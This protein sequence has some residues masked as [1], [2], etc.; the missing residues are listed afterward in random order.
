MSEQD[1]WLGR[2]DQ[3]MMHTF[4]TPARVFVSGQGTKLRDSDGREYIDLFSGIAVG[5]LGH[6]HP[7]IIEAVTNQVATLGHISNL[8]ASPTQIEL[9]ERLSGLV[10]AAGAASAKVYFANSGAEANEA[11]F[12]ITRLS[13]RKRIIAMTG[14]FHGRT[15]GALALTSTAK[16]REPFN[17]LPGQ[18][19]FVPY[20]DAEALAAVLDTTVAAVVLETIQGES[21]VVPA[22]EGYLA[23][24]RELCDQYGALLWVDEVQTGI[25]RCGEWLTSIA[26]GVIP[27][28]ITLAKG[29]GNGIPI[30]ATIA[31]GR[32]AELFTPGSHGSTFAGNPI[33]CAAGLAVL[34]TISSGRLLERTRELGDYLEALITSLN[35]PLI[36]QVRGRGLLL[37]I[38]LG[39]EIA[40]EIVAELLKAGWITN[41]PRPDVIRIAPPLVIDIAEL[42]GFVQTLDAML[43]GRCDD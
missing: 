42:D 25:G 35:N 10:K 33:A 16:Y 12:K 37:G 24:A 43:K 20:G 26:D 39:A 41:A 8:F 21:G 15:M 4:G 9:A 13:G 30:G 22:P 2:W 32:A 23:K 1:S 3:A 28:L 11:A 19:D 38:V 18:V 40:P 7:A 31:T 29:L 5:G 27:D 14:S 17:P 36:T 6:A 34:D